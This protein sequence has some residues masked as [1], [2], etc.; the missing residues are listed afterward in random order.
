MER[1][2]AIKFMND[3]LRALL[4]KNGSDLFLSATYPPAFKVDG[5]MTPRSSARA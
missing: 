3:L 2:Q 1:D 4:A 5:R